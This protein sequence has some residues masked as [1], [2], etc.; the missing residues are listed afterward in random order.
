MTTTNATVPAPMRRNNAVT[1]RARMLA[2]YIDK[3]PDLGEA[4]SVKA[5]TG[6]LGS[7]IHLDGSRRFDAF[8]AWIYR[9]SNVAIISYATV[10]DV[11][12]VL[13]DGHPVLVYGA[14][15]KSFTDEQRA[16]LDDTISVHMLRR[17]QIDGVQ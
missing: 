6:L 16:A 9:L 4:I 14:K 2:E 8:L 17:W 15:P 5:A 7:E 12:G 11:R 10:I 1:D 13:D 3:H